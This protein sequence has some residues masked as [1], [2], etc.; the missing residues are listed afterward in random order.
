MNPTKRLNTEPKHENALNHRKGW[1]S[2]PHQD[3]QKG[4]RCLVIDGHI[5]PAEWL[6][7]N[8]IR[9]PTRIILP[10][11]PKCLLTSWYWDSNFFIWISNE[12]NKQK[13]PKKKR[14]KK[15]LN[16]EKSKYFTHISMIPHN[17]L[18]PKSI[19]Y[20]LLTMGY[21]WPNIDNYPHSFLFF[22][23]LTNPNYFYFH[24]WKN[25]LFMSNSKPFNGI[26]IHIV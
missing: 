4:K 16:L 5:I 17:Y 1:T 15:R 9:I 7:T 13:K 26:I 14:K 12:K 19:L 22:E 24:R 6:R 18:T 8:K 23:I 2:H 25:C 20:F 21:K 10:T 11:D 3:L